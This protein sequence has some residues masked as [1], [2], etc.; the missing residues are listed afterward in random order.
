MRDRA[1]AAGQLDTTDRLD[2]DMLALFAERVRPTPRPLPEPVLQ[3]L[4]ALMTRRRQLLDMFKSL[5]DT[6]HA[7]IA[8]ALAHELGPNGPL[9]YRAQ[10]ILDCVTLPV[11]K[12]KFDE[13]DKLIENSSVRR[14]VFILHGIR[15]Y[16]TWGIELKQ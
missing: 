7:D 3:H 15:D 2:A 11:D 4:D 12:L 9:T 16:D 13:P 8:T 14:I 10:T 6:D 5:P 1:K